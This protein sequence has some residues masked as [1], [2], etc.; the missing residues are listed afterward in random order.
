MDLSACTDAD[1]YEYVSS[2][3]NSFE[4]AYPKYLFNRSYVNDAGNQYTLE[5][6]NSDK[7][8]DY[9]SKSSHLITK[10]RIR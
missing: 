3:D 6:A 9:R 10:S 4:F 5:Y 2:D 8:D 1:D 7:D